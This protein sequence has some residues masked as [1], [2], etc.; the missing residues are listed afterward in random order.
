AVALA[1]GELAYL[2]LLVAALEV[3][4]GDVAAALHLALAELDLVEPAGDLLPHGL[5]RAERLARL[6]DIAELHRG[7]DAQGTAIG[8]LLSRDHAEE[9]GLAG[10]VGSDD[11]DDAA[12]RQLEGEIVDQQ[13]L[14]EALL[15]VCRLDDQVTQPWPRR[16][17]DLAAIGRAVGVLGQQRLVG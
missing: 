12:R 8:L 7:T 14:A 1:A 15:Q 5:L 10:A 16:D 9:R 2:L 4:A 3:E 6:V 17:R 13:P 11:A